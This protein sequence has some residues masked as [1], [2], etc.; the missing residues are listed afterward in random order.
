MLELEH[1]A[2]YLRYLKIK[3]GHLCMFIKSVNL[4][5][6][7]IF[8]SVVFCC[9]GASACNKDNEHL[10]NDVRDKIS[11]NAISEEDIKKLL[12]HG[13]RYD[14]S[15]I[16][17]ISNAEID[18]FYQI[19]LDDDVFYVSKDGRY[20]FFGN[21][22]DL[23]NGKNITQDAVNLV[24]KVDWDRLPLDGAI[25]ITKGDNPKAKIAVFVDPDCPYCKKIEIEALSHLSD[26]EIYLFFFPLIS[27][28]PNAMNKSK[29][30]WCASDPI[31]AW[32][33][34][35]YNNYQNNNDIRAN[36]DILK[37]QKAFNYAE[38]VLKI[39][40]VPT[41]I[42]HNGVR[43]DSIYDPNKLTSMILN[44]EKDR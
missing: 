21:I 27:I 18:N 41:I 26:V 43:V 38:Q 7:S 11:Q 29:A 9:F 16:K 34:F 40:Q 13:M 32:N 5:F 6:I 36:C 10:Y 37:M 17:S 14:I 42:L 2:C 8:L 39:D 3:I 20:A 22:I 25:K 33:S 30:I 4:R 35:V 1:L 28:H 31:A 12:Q 19:T 23:S 15:K 24:T 44:A